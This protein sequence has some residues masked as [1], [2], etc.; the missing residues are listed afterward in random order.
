MKQ[1]ITKILAVI[2]A[3]III[4]GIVITATKGLNFNIKYRANN[5]IEFNLNTEY[6]E[7]DI[8]E[9]TNEVFGNQEVIIQP[10]EVYKDALKITTSEITDEQK[11]EL[12]SKVNEKYSLE[13]VAEDIE[14]TENAN[15]KGIS[16]IE[17]YIIPFAIITIII[18]VYQMIRFN[19]LN[20]LKVLLKSIC[21]IACS[22]LLLLSI[23]AITRIPVGEYIT[24]IILAVYILAIGVSNTKFEKDLEKKKL[25]LS[26]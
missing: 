6:S 7:S 13:L 20:S 23:F 5:S 15:I 17:Q 10:I 3:I 22:E 1:K 26:K 8:K 12:V 9:I 25:E 2:I 18:L 24:A 19:K 21:V 4:I 11:S 16:I 14:I